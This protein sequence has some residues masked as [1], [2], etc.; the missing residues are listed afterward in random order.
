MKR[1]ALLSFA[2]LCCADPNYSGLRIE[3]LDDPTVFGCSPDTLQPGDLLTIS[4]AVPHWG[5]LNVTTPDGVVFPL[6][7]DHDP[8]F[9]GRSIV[10]F[11]DFPSI[12]TFV[13][14]TNALTQVPYIRGQLQPSI[15]FSQPG[16]YTFL[17]TEEFASDLAEAYRCQVELTE[18]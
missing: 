10:P 12:Q 1:T 13:F 14:G 5:F 2:V 4:M 3:Y 16:H 11:A 6:V 15:V 8:Y 17:L 9:P 7:F 18:P